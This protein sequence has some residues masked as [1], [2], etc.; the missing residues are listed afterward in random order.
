MEL[1]KDQFRLTVK[2]G[3]EEVA[4]HRVLA[5]Q[6]DQPVG[7]IAW[8]PSHGEIEDIE[9]HPDFRRQGVATSLY[10]KATEWSDE[11]GQVAPRHSSIRTQAGH[12]WAIR[13]GGEAEPLEQLMPPGS[14]KFNKKR[15]MDHFQ[16]GYSGYHEGY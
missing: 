11:N 12:R 9:T 16:D 1:N 7:F 13:V 2:P 14:D 10:K 4:P 6:G 3:E 5:H 8:N 15:F